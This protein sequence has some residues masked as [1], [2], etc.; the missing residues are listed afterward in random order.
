MRFLT[1]LFS[2]C[3]TTLLLPA[4]D[5]P[6]WRGPHADGSSDE[7]NLPD[8]CDDSTRLWTTPLPGIG[9]GTPAIWGDRVFVTAI[10][11]DTAMFT[12]VCVDRATGAVRWQAE[13]GVAFHSQHRDDLAAASPVCDG[14]RVMVTFGN[15]DLAAFTH[16]GEKIWQRNLQQ[17]YGKFT[18][19]WIYGSTP[20]LHRGLLIVQVLQTNSDTVAAT[21]RTTSYVL[22][23]DPVTGKDRWKQARPCT[24]RGE[25]QDAYTSPIPFVRGAK[26]EVLVL[27]GD[28]L[29]GH[30]L[31]TGVEVWRCGDW[32]ER[33]AN[34]WRMI[35]TPVVIDGRVVMCTARGNRLIAVA[36]HEDGTLQ[37]AW[38]SKELSSD[39][40]TP[41]VYA[42]NIYV[43]NGDK[44]LLACLN[45]ST[46]MLNW[47]GEYTSSGVVRS[48][49]TAG[50]G[51]IYALS[52]AGE[53][54]VFANDSF[55]LISRNA[56]ESA[57]PARAS[58]A[59]A[60]GQVFVRT[61]DHLHVFARRS[62]EGN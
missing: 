51:R 8:R 1:F 4:A 23:I 57:G 54:L 42:G 37:P 60:H 39:V 18:N 50:D 56:L 15:G 26:H 41:L 36:S 61:S 52:E 22:G 55:R 10:N 48:S 21:P 13:V 3:L 24:A 5:W 53:V 28:C 45:P 6:Q 31:A 43:L 32:N 20:L 62:S 9:A 29:T 33:R 35:T 17:D 11:R 44:R 12:V 25:S 47:S 7:T 58:I 30:D 16:A 59:L 40:A 38:E 34:N 14:E 19:Q 2:A 27:G 49:P 46:G